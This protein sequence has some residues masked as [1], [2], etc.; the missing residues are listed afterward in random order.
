[1]LQNYVGSVWIGA[2]V[3]D[4]IKEAMNTSRSRSILNRFTKDKVGYLYYI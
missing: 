1:M 2:K 4:R 3:A